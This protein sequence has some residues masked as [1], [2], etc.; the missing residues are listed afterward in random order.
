MKHRTHRVPDLLAQLEAFIQSRRVREGFALLDELRKKIRQTNGLEGV[1]A[2]SLALCLA[3]WVDLGY[4][5]H[6]LFEV[7]IKKLP[8]RHSELSFLDVMRLNL[9]EAYSCLAAENLDRAIALLDQTAIAGA[10]ILPEYLIFL[11][12]FWKGRSH[13]KKGEYKDA[14]WHIHAARASAERLVNEKLVAVAKIHE[15]WLVF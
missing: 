13:R 6:S 11:T 2:I 15:S 1:N 8:E 7:V 9:I 4:R 10:E 12:H 3:Q 14:A 5:D